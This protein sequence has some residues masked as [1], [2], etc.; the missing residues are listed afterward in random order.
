MATKTCKNGHAY[1]ASIYGQNCP[2]CP[3]E[4]GTEKTKV[5]GG[6]GFED[7]TIPNS[8]W[9]QNNL[10]DS[11]KP[12]TPIG[13]EEQEGGHTVIRSAN[14]TRVGPNG[15]GRKLVGLLVSYSQNAAG[16]VFKV[17]EGNTLIGREKSRCDIAF[18]ND[19]TMSREHLSIQYVAAKGRFAAESLG[20]N[21]SYINGQV[22]DKLDKTFELKNNDIII[23]GATKF[24]FLAI[25]PLYLNQTEENG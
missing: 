12:T 15:G 5:N 25:P 2:F 7:P 3:Q 18:P 6:N 19:T 4:D 1:D 23:L 17:Y 21:G 16:E 24:V 22:Y 13:E 8:S 10:T 20:S 14:G 11:T 9:G